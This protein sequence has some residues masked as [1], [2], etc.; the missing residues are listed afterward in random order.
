MPDISP[1]VL[2]DDEEPSRRWFLKGMWA[3]FSVPGLILASA[4]VGFAS[5]AREEGISLA[6]SLFMTL[7]VWALPAVVVLIGAIKSGATIFAAA[8]AVTLSSMR[9]MLMV[10]ALVPEMR[11]PKTRP[12][13]LYLLSH[14]VAVTSWVMAFQNF[15]AVPREGRTA[16]YGGVATFL[17]VANLGVVAVVYAIVQDLPAVISA[18][19]LLLT[20]LYFLTSLWGTAREN[21][22]KVAMVL[23]IVL[24]PVCHVLVPGF[25]LAAAGLIGGGLAYGFHRMNQAA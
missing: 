13:V 9:L 16:F 19:L 15:P 18:A 20:P 12:W 22:G 23:G 5:L 21:A 6:Q 2:T 25:D 8:F 11:T 17:M 7:T 24:G 14:F 4:F 1:A 10:V 3:C